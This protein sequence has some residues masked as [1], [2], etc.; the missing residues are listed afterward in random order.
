MP[1][2]RR[3]SRD[4]YVRKGVVQLLGVVVMF[5]LAGDAD[6]ASAFPALAGGV[7]SG[8]WSPSWAMRTRRR[9]SRDWHVRKGVVLVQMFFLF[10]ISEFP[11]V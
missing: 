5:A 9:R 10:C 4:L 3:R 8:F 6:E 11:E 2:R 7:A 1:T